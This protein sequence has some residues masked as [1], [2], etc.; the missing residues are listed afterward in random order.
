METV[1]ENLT[2]LQEIL[3]WNVKQG[4]HY[5]RIGS[6]L[7][8]FASH[9]VCSVDWAKIWAPEFDQIGQYILNNKLRIAMH[10]DQFVLLHSPRPEVVE[11]SVRELLYHAQVL[12][13]MGLPQS[14]KVQ[15][16][17]GGV[18]GDKAESVA[19]FVA[20]FEA[21]PAAVKRRLVIE[22]DDR[23]YDVQ[24]CLQISELTGIPVLLDV[25]HHRLLNRGETLAQAF[26]MVQRTWKPE[27]GL[28]LVDYSS[29]QLGA[30]AGAHAETVDLADFKTV[31]RELKAYDFDIMLEIKDKERSAL[32]VRDM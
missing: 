30:R 25:F 20:G 7:I 13:L 4:F 11:S 27:D 3:A 14:A 31:M 17:V 10:P 5:F 26:E 28:V 23:L 9:P 12:D 21:L 16:H 18:Y 2:C 22:H 32:R 8:P 1:S 6:E 29:Q 19:R 24:D 15:I